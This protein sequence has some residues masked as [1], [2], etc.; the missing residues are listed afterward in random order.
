MSNSVRSKPTSIPHSLNPDADLWVFGYGSLMWK[1]GFDY[2]ERVPATLYGAHRALCV[3]S[4]RHRGT[5]EKPGVVLGLDRGGSCH[6]FVFRVA[7]QNVAATHAY[8]TEREQ[9]NKVYHEVLHM[10]HL[11]DGR[12]IRALAYLVDPSHSQYTGRLD[13]AAL[14][15]LIKQG[16]GQS[17]SCRDYVLNTLD[18][19]A[20]LGI[21]DHALAWLRPALDT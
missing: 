9:M 5:P 1:P 13:H 19:L 3:S 7:A 8:L 11:A 14:L 4:V 10:V 2:V 17:G 16:Y 21:N 20:E 12:K 15:T 18:A 6:G